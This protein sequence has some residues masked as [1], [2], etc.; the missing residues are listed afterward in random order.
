MSRFLSP[1]AQ[2][3]TPYIPG[4]QPQDRRYIKLNTNE[5]PYSPSP[6]VLKAIAG[7]A[8]GSLR[9]YPDPESRRLGAAAAKYYSL[10]PEQVFVGGGS[11][12]VLA[13][14]FMAFFQQGDPVCY[15]DITYGIYQVYARLFHLD[16]RIV[17]LREDFALDP[18]SFSG[19][20]GHIFLANPNAPTGLCLSPREIEEILRQDT[21]RLVVVDEAYIDFAGGMTC[22]PLLERYGN[23]FIVRTFSK[24]R[25][26]A[27]MRIGLGLGS[28]EVIEDISRVNFSFNPYN[29]SRTSMAAGIA[30]LEDEEY[31]RE[32]VDTITATRDRALEQLGEM[33]FPALPSRANFLFVHAGPLGGRELYRALKEWGILVRYFDKPRIDRYIRVTVGTDQEMDVFLGTLRDIYANL[34]E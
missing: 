5:S 20:R 23:L 32:L 6:K 34:N 27:G 9:L 24:S 2:G 4:E 12:E 3:L 30:A 21:D 17:P 8:G 29:L 1:A 19:Q 7:E 28:R 15:P 11:D 26:L 33:G 16:S 31:F 25:A 14:A 13:Y 10:A 22:L 18:E